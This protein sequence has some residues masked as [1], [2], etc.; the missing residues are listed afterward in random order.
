MCF[1][2]YSSVVMLISRRFTPDRR[3]VTDLNLNVRISKNNLTCPLL[4]DTLSVHR[5]SRC[6]VLSVLDVKDAFHSISL[7]ENSERFFGILQYFGSA[8]YLYQR[9]PMVL[10]TSPSI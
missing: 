3:V 1:S 7:S 9:M 8:S 4:K 5:N 6:E 10:Y 2:A